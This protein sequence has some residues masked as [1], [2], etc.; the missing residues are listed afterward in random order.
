[1][2]SFSYLFIRVS[3]FQPEPKGTDIPSV[4]PPSPLTSLL[5]VCSSIISSLPSLISMYSSS[6]SALIEGEIKSSSVI[7][8]SIQHIAASF[9]LKPVFLKKK[10]GKKIAF[11]SLKARY[12]LF[13]SG[14]Y[15]WVVFLR[16]GQIR[17]VMIRWKILWRLAFSNKSAATEECYTWRCTALKIIICTRK[18]LCI[19][20]SWL[21]PEF[22]LNVMC[23][24]LLPS[25]RMNSYLKQKEW[26][27]SADS[28]SWSWTW[29]VQRHFLFVCFIII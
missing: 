27:A 10:E 8:G 23:F 13:K 3:S 12:I 18:S 2:S 28:M 1:M 4:P 11:V 15:Q 26:K 6:Y 24:Q 22:L 25:A 17:V 20:F 21:H 7:S 19:D 29:H 14:V 9:N 16:G 5:S